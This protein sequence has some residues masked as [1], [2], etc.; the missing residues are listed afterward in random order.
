MYD[1]NL[2]LVILHNKMH[3]SYY[4]DINSNDNYN[5]RT[6]TVRSHKHSVHFRVSLC[7]CFQKS[8][9]TAR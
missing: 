2:S 3:S 9:K 4:E 6:V 5:K 7:L 8:Y 1:N